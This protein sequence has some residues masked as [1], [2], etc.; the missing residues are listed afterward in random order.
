MQVTS[1]RTH[2]K[3]FKAAATNMRYLVHKKF[4]SQENFFL[5]MTR[6]FQV[7]ILILSRE[8]VYLFLV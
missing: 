7:R 5:D 1:V 8:V 3:V 2:E 4:S 6:S